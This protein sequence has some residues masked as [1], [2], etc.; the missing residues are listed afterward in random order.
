MKGFLLLGG[1]FLAAFLLISVLCL[2]PLASLLNAQQQ[3][4][5][6]AVAQA[7]LALEQH[8]YGPEMN[9]YHDDAFMHPVIAYWQSLCHN[10]L[11]GLCSVAVSGN[12]QCVEFVAAAQWLAGNPLPAIDNAQ[13]FWPAYAHEPGWREIPSPTSFPGAPPVAPQVGDLVVWQGGAHLEQQAN[14]SFKNVSY[15]HIAVITKFVPPTR[16]TDGLIAL[17]QANA[18]AGAFSLAI[19]PDYTV[20]S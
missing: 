17:G 10:V 14:G 18:L 1:A 12:L 3:G 6:S 13:D 8:I 11:G 20:Q 16:S 19:H 15:G 2:A 5:N 9:E 7:A 4:S